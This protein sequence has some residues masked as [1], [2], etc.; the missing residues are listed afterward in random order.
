VDV[1]DLKGWL[2]AVVALTRGPAAEL[3]PAE[4]P[5]G[6]YRPGWTFE[7]VDADGAVCGVAGA[8]HPD[9]LD[10]PPWAGEVFGVELTLPAQPDI[11][12]PRRA[13]P[14]PAHPGSERD[15][16]LFL[17]AD[18]SAARVAEVARTSG[19]TLLAGVEVFDRY[20]GEGVPEGMAA[21]GWRF[22]YQAPDRT[23]TDEEVDAAT[24]RIAS[25]L[26]EELSA[27]I[28]GRED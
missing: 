14:L 5:A 27:R 19:G 28:R 11:T 18:V 8:L 4:A 15:L 24:D 7:V 13:Q 25:A 22:R 10:L 16:A 6:G 20:E 17:P 2:E 1:W 21:L 26:E 12:D 23:L 3:R 9:T